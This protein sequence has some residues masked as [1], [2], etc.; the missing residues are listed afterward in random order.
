MG[1]GGAAAAA[2]AACPEPAG[3]GESADVGRWATSGALQAV[4][5]T[6][7]GTAP[8]EH[9]AALLHPQPKDRAR[10]VRRRLLWGEHCSRCCGGREL[11]GR[12]G[13]GELV[14]AAVPLQPGGATP[15]E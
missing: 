1:K 8:A 4:S 6:E 5:L 12:Q 9:D 13:G 14:S 3:E 7:E 15:V 11:Q 10:A 2:Q